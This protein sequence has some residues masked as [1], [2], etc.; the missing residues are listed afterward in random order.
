MMNK[1]YYTYYLQ[2]A[3]EKLIKIQ[4]RSKLDNS[5]NAAIYAHNIEKLLAYSEQMN[6]SIKQQ[7]SH[8]TR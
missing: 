3:A 2:Q 7:R 4:I 8:L 1:Q 5:N 6:M